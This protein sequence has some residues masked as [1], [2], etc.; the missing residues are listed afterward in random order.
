MILAIATI[1]VERDFGDLTVEN[2]IAAARISRT[3]FHDLFTDKQEAALFA[4]E[5]LFE[6]FLAAIRDACDGQQEWPEKVKAAIGASFE[7]A[8]ALPAQTHLLASDF[9]GDDP[10][11]AARARSS[12]QQLADLL[13]EGRQHYPET[14]SLPPVTEEALIGALRSLITRGLPLDETERAAMRSQLVELTL[15]PYLGLAKAA[16]VSQGK[17]LNLW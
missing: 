7:F 14:A 6:R 9:L 11:L 13:A 17:R 4:Q 16:A 8:E 15:I 3:T 2:I 1:L 10:V 12:H 5:I